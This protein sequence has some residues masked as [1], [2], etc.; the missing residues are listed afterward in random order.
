MKSLLPV[1]TAVLLVVFVSAHA[2]PSAAAKSDADILLQL[3]ADFMKAAAERGSPGYMSYYAEDAAELPNGVDMFRGKES[4]AKTMD[5]LDDKNNR[6]TW[7]PV[8][9][10]MAASGDLGYTYGPPS[11]APETKTENQRLNMASTSA[12]GRNRKMGV[13]KL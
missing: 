12:F 6:L 4:I 13:G 5:F 7:K 2:S 9:A 8:Y 11:S 1:F 10:D 3:E